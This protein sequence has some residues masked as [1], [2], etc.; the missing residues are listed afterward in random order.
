MVAKLDA[1]TV[2]AAEAERSAAEAKAKAEADAIMA[3][4]N[5]EADAVIAANPVIAD[6]EAF[7]SLY[8]SCPETA[9]AMLACLRKDM[10]VPQP[11]AAVPATQAEEEAGDKPTDGATD[12]EQEVVV[13]NA[14]KP[15][16][17]VV[18]NAASAKLPDP[19]VIAHS[20]ALRTKAMSLSG[21]AYL[22][23]MAANPSLLHEQQ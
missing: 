20:N 11:V 22:D 13:D 19:D 7:K 4:R 23:F 21:Q 6:A 17:G 16:R 5:A 8:V 2:A 9:M 18:L 15:K 3:A 10:V 12:P 14:C 1:F